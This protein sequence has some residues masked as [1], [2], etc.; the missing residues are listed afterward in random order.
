[1][2]IP[3]LEFWVLDAQP[4]PHAAAPVLAFRLRARD[5]SEREIY[6]AALSVQIQI[7]AAQRPHDEVTRE[8]LFELFGE[9]ERWG[10][11][12]R[13][14]LWTREEVLLPSFTGSVTHDLHVP[15]SS[16]AELASFKYFNALPDGEVPLSFHFSGTVF[17]AGEQ[18]RMQL[19]QVS[20][21][22]EAQFRLP[23]ETWR[24]T[25]EEHHPPGGY[26]HLSDETLEALRQL[27]EERGFMSLDAVLADLAMGART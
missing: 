5:R 11:T 8:R 7:E 19:T 1:M 24:R 25:I 2:S 10:D 18:D 6:T 17:Y 22:A 27:R 14:V 13:G 15:L 9:P 3:E 23:I 20:W 16:D 26:V 12:A 21:S 4:V